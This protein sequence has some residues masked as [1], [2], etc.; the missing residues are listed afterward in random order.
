MSYP[1][2]LQRRLPVLL[3]ASLAGLGLAAS[4]ALA[5]SDGDEPPAIEQPP[6]PPSPSPLP[7][8]QPAAPAP[9]P[10]PQPSTPQPTT[11]RPTSE[12]LDQQAQ[13]K[14]ANRQR[15]TRQVSFVTKTHTTGTAVTTIP[16]GGVQAGAGGTSLEPGMPGA[17]IG[18]A[19]GSLVLLLA[20]AGV[21]AR[22]RGTASR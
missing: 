18:L 7:L 16:T 12:V 15:T 4:P 5:G 6:A 22:R 21:A 10:A 17:S 20:S 1:T 19:G 9:S 11:P 2:I 13:K 8:P 14:K 3:A